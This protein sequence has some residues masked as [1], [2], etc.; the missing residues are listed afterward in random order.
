MKVE[1]VRT[2]LICERMKGG[3]WN[4][5][6]CG[7]SC[8]CPNADRIIDGFASEILVAV[9]GDIADAVASRDAEIARLKA[10]RDGSCESFQLG[11]EPCAGCH[12]QTA[13]DEI[14]SL[15]SII[16]ELLPRIPSGAAIPCDGCDENCKYYGDECSVRKLQSLL[17]KANEV[18][19]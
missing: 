19:K 6:Q 18:L 2:A 16:R 5:S 12:V 15:R 7:D 8:D 17:Q 9:K 14:E 3:D 13:V 1:A 11:A 10:C 4:C